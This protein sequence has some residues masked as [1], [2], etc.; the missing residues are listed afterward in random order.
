[1]KRNQIYLANQEWHHPAD[2]S[3]SSEI[4]NCPHAVSF[5]S[6]FF[7][8]H[9]AISANQKVSDVIGHHAFC[10]PKQYSSDNNY[11]LQ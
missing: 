4:L 3:E 7:L 10:S 9:L 5:Y 2:S 6:P 11:K 1:M 8:I